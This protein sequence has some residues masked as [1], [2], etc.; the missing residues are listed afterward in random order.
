LNVGL[1]PADGRTA[2]SIGVSSNAEIET[3]FDE[4]SP[5][6]GLL[7]IAPLVMKPVISDGISSRE[8]SNVKEMSW[9]PLVVRVGAKIRASSI[10]E[11]YKNTR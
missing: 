2:G 1:P 6:S 4:V 3:I 10:L 8:L 9:V 5:E 11:T 7:V